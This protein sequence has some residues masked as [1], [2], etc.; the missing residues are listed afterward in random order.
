[1]LQSARIDSVTLTPKSGVD[2]LAF[3]SSLTLVVHADSGDIPLIDASGNMA[4]ADGSVILPIAVD[5][6]PT[7]LAKPIDVTATVGFAAPAD[8]WTM[9]IDATLT[10]RGHVDLHP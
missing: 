5:I 10:V 3:L 4:G 1:M 7:L 8:A 2:S 9:Q 6:D